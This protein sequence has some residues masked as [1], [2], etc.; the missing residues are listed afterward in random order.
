VATLSVWKFETPSGADQAEQALIALQKQELIQVHDAAT[1]SWEPGK[2]KPKT[3]QAHN[4]A[5]AGALGGTFWG[6]L[7]GLLFVVPLLGAAI[8][9]AAGALGGALSDVGID[10][11]FID[12]VRSTVT[13][14]TSALF[15]LSSGA[16]PDKCSARSGTRA[17]TRSSSRRTSRPRR[18]RASARR[19]RRTSDAPAGRGEHRAREVVL[20]RRG[21]HV[22]VTTSSSCDDL[23]GPPP[24]RSRAAQS[25]PRWTATRTA[26]RRPS[27]PSLR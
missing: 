17:S 9:A 27:T 23:A 3:R 12:S 15:L 18:R 5:A 20:T 14:G 13:P 22:H 1:L 19:S 8:G 6:M 10:D 7:F 26:A 2:S 11:D 24:D 21:R 16:V 4:L 25:R